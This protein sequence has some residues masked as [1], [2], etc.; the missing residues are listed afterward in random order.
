MEDPIVIPP[1]TKPKEDVLASYN[2]EHGSNLTF[3]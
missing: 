3:A 1:K 2:A